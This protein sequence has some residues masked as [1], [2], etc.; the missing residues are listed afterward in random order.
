ME[1]PPR[2]P[3]TIS[4]AI[5]E[6]TEIHKRPQPPNRPLGPS[7]S[8]TYSDYTRKPIAGITRPIPERHLPNI[9]PQFRPNAKISTGHSPAQNFNQEPGNIRISGQTLKRPNSSPQF[10]HRRQPLLQQQQHRYPLNR[11]ADFGPGAPLSTDAN[12]RVYR[13]PPYGGQGVQYLDRMYPRRPLP[14]PQRGA[15]NYERHAA[16]SNSEVYKTIMAPERLAAFEEEDLVINDPPQPV[17]GT[18]EEQSIDKSK[19]EQVVTL[20]MLQS[21]K[22]PLALPNDDTGSGEI[23]V[24]AASEQTQPPL[25]STATQNGLYVVYPSRGDKVKAPEVGDV[26]DQL[27][28]I[29]HV[30]PPTGSDYQN[31]PFSVLRAQPQ[32]PILKN[33]KPQSLQQQ[34]KIQMIKDKFPYP[35]EKPDLTHSELSMPVH[36]TMVGPRIIN[37]AYGV[38]MPDTPIAIAYSPT[39]PSPYRRAGVSAPPRFSN[40]NLASS[41]IS[42]IR[43]DT[44]TEEGLSNDFDTRG[45]N[46]EKNF[47]APFYP[48]VSLGSATNAPPNGWNILPS[49]T[50]KAVYEKN[51]INRADVDEAAPIELTEITTSKSFEMDS[52]QPELQGGFKPIYPPGYKLENEDHAQEEP[53]E[54]FVGEN[55][56]P[57]ALASYMRPESQEIGDTKSSTPTSIIS[58]SSTTTS[59]TSTTPKPHTSSSA[60]PKNTAT[61][62]TST[63]SVSTSNAPTNLNATASMDT[64]KAPI[65]TIIPTKKKSTF[66]TSLA[67]LLFGDDE[68]F[69]DASEARKQQPLTATV[70]TKTVS[71]GPRAG[72]PRMGPRSLQ[73]S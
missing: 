15:D 31:T 12:R 60:K 46:L 34:T 43:T 6:H 70:E 72:A 49:T 41:V 47:M 8:F 56:K 68:E 10:A 13:L 55:D 30:E 53:E 62:M 26:K 4:N 33:K 48:S 61:P 38:G 19:L 54:V 20:Q 9:L 69:E 29:A 32:E 57:L 1:P 37:G 71:A 51:N 25:E 45:Q 16:A 7:S 21:Q 35:I 66:E 65:T 14:S 23:Q 44:Q 18:Q 11:A 36:G 22:K 27:P 3:T 5:P 2:F 50:E 52:F 24:T 67:A 58:T 40:V 17:A 73:F 28:A 63:T 39:E 42:E 59:T 64:T